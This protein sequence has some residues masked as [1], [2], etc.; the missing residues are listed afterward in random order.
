MRSE[1]STAPGGLAG[2]DHL[3]GI[4][5]R[6]LEA[7]PDLVVVAVPG[8]GRV[9]VNAA[10]TRLLGIAGPAVDPDALGQRVPASARQRI[11]DEVVPA[12]ETE[13]VWEGELAVHDAEGDI[14]PLDI[15]ASAV[16]DDGSGAVEA[17]V[18]IA[19]DASPG[20]ARTGQLERQATH[21]A[22]TALPNRTLLLDR[23]GL[24]LGRAQRHASLVA[25]LVLDLD[26]FKPVNDR[27]GHA[28]GDVLLA[29]VA[30]RIEATI[31]PGD[32]A[33]RVGGD[34]FVVVCEDLSSRDEAAIVARRIATAV[35][36]PVRIEGTEVT[37]TASIGLA[38]SDPAVTVDDL[39]R[40]ADAAMYEA[41]NLRG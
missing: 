16:R 36:R 17:V 22:L 28:A 41:K 31:R 34:E 25:V 13:G 39:L 30:R 4:V 10:T 7:S 19:R 3:A 8:E 29:E 1:G 38:L 27:L 32:T 9:H 2:D 40:R 14:V 37:V 5:A 33:A 24:A 12:V 15:T 18:V 26:G 6:A 20:A 23:L 11:L 35:A 21:D